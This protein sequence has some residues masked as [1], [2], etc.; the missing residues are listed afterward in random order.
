MRRERGLRSAFT[1][2]ELL[3]VMT[4]IALLLALLL[5]AVQAAREAARRTSC[6][7]NLK[8]IGVALHNY[9]GSH[10]T[11]P[12][13]TTSQI[14]YGVWSPVPVDHHL[15][16]WATFILPQ[17]DQASLFNT[18]NFNVSAIAPANYEPAAQKLACYRC[19][20][21][22]GPDFSLAPLYVKLSPRFATRN[23]VA[24]G[25]TTIGKLWQSP[26]GSIYP[27]SSTRFADIADGTSQTILVAETREPNASVWIDGGV[28]ALTSRRYHE[29]RSPSFAGTENALNYQPFFVANGQGIDAQFGPSSTHT[30]GVNHLLADGSVRFISE[31][32]NGVIYDCL[33]TRGGHEPIMGDAF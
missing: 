2:I 9:A 22:T 11:L 7:N 23:Y 16:S 10:G 33:V 13:S 29:E 30:G 3:V 14:D 5:P 18:I 25:A 24:M 12:P 28:A 4:V 6:R 19:P 27:R 15:Q 8:Q 31:N 21:F 20:S 17:L 1:L 32:I 26:D